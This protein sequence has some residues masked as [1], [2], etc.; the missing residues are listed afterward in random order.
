MGTAPSR[1]N[2]CI[3]IFA[4]E[5]FCVGCPHMMGGDSARQSARHWVIQF[6][7]G[8]TSIT[9]IVG[10]RRSRYLI[11]QRSTTPN[12]SDFTQLFLSS[13]FPYFAQL[14]A[15]HSTW[16]SDKISNKLAPIRH[17]REVIISYIAAH[18]AYR[19]CGHSH[20]S[21]SAY[22]GLGYPKERICGQRAS[23]RNSFVQFIYV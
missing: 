19:L 22:G 1:K 17:T 8:A 4:A 11:R 14:F 9:G 23:L 12:T 6:L 2:N 10:D 18:V 13:P 16:T 21:D 3:I 5:F 20:T 7:H 15:T